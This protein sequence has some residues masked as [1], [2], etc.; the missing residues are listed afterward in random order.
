MDN[1]R[2]ALLASL[3]LAGL[4]PVASAQGPAA[5]GPERLVVRF[6]ALPSGLREH[7]LYEGAEILGIDAAGGFAVVQA[8]HGQAFRASAQGQ[9]GV[10]SVE[11]DGIVHSLGFT[12]NDPMFASPQ[13]A[14]KLIGAPAAWATTLG[15]P[16]ATLC[17]VDSGVRRT[18]QD[19]AAHYA[20][21]ID[22]VS[23]DNDPADDN[24]H[25]TRTAGVA[26]AVIDNGLGISG[27]ANVPFKEVK[28]LNAAGSGYDSDIATGIRWCADNGARIVSISIGGAGVSTAVHDA[29][30]YAWGKGLVLVAGAGNGGCTGC[31]LYPAAFPNVIA[32]GA[33]D[34]SAAVQGFT[35]QGPEM[36]LAAPGVN[37]QTTG[38]GSDTSY[39]MGGGT[40]LSA[41]HVAGAAAL[42]WSAHPTWTNQHVRTALEATA[43]DVGPVGI[44]AWSG[45]GMVRPDLAIAFGSAPALASFTASF[46]V[47]S[48]SNEWW[49]EV[50]VASSAVPAK[51]ELSASG[52]AWQALAL[53]SWGNWA[54]NVHVAKGTPI[55]FRATDAAGHTAASASQPWLGA[56][57]TSTTSASTTPAFA[58][59]FT[60]KAVGNDWWVETAVGANAPIA[61]VEAKVNGGAWTALPKTDWGTYAKSMAA[62]NGSTVTFRAT[63]S[64]GATATSAPMTWT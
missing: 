57:A 35:S 16:S 12:P 4:V 62:P 47:A 13:Y 60:P 24:G 31:V 32:V 58:A 1:L 29:V 22:L 14:P 61:K 28:V 15:A 27:M 40:S 53:K 44:D 49:E 10:R 11:T 3:L 18:H 20:G 17:L 56:V 23:H 26:A 19:L 36:D 9:H 45:H 42:V 52:G 21:G 59:T 37:I 2:A 55:V 46:A 38:Y 8:S 50:K 7:G 51:V 41:P 54:A 43:Q 64:T 30:D 34:S 5:D 39:L 33:V 6:D 63:S 48:G 25:G